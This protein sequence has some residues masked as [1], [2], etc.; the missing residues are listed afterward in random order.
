ME[1]LL[2]FRLGRLDLL[3]VDEFGV[4]KGCMLAYQLKRTPTPKELKNGENCE[5]S[6]EVMQAGIYGEQW[7]YLTSLVPSGEIGI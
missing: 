7:I 5:H 1:M 4:R 3:P 2:I 6:I